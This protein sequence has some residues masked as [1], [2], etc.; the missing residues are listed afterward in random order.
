MAKFDEQLLAT[1]GNWEQGL[2]TFLGRKNLT[3]L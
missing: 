1:G 3:G 2:A